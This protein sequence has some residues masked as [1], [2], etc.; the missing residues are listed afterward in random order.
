MPTVLR[1]LIWGAV[2]VGNLAFSDAPG[3]GRTLYLS[4][5]GYGCGVCHGP[6][7]NGAGQAGG[8]IRG[9]TLEVLEVA[10]AEQ[11]TMQLLVNV[12]SAE[13]I[14]AIADYL[15]SLGSI[16]LVEMS[17]SDRGWS[18]TQK[19][20]SS[21]QTVQ[22]VVFNASFADLI[23]DLSAFG[24]ATVTIGALDTKVF[25]WV[26]EAGT[27]ALPDNALLVVTA[28]E[29]C[30]QRSATTDQGISS[31]KNQPDCA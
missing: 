15:G 12:L 2:F 11:P 21:G 18:I 13:D 23:I 19:P 25:E 24:F 27:Y 10:L 14:A 5:G 20:A 31:L 30:V 3:T 22:F 8:S 7:A 4:A 9:A 26:A 1:H 6:V 16:P 29:R 28:S 17:Y